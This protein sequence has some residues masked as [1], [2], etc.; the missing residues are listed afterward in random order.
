MTEAEAAELC[1]LHFRVG[2]AA[3][4]KW[5]IEEIERMIAH[6]GGD[7]EARFGAL[8]SEALVQRLKMPPTF[9][10]VKKDVLG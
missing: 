3:A 2:H 1:E 7:V 5:A 9:D 4:L 6:R 8:L 10:E